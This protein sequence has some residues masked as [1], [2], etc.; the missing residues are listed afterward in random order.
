MPREKH[1]TLLRALGR[2]QRNRHMA[3]AASQR[4]FKELPARLQHH[5]AVHPSARE[6]AP[7]SF[8]AGYK[9]HPRLICTAATMPRSFLVDS[10]I[11]REANDK[12]S[13][14]SSP[15]FP[16][17]V[18][19]PGHHPHGLPGS[20]HS[21]KAGLLCF[22][23]LCM[24]ASQLHP[25]PP[26]LPLL[27]ASFPAFGSQYCH[28]ALSRQHTSS[29]INLGHGA[30]MYQAAYTVPDPRQYHCISIE[31]SNSKLQSSKRMRTAFTSTQL[32]ELEREFTSNMYL[33]RLRRI[34]IATYLNLSEKQVKIWFQ[35]RRVKHKKEGKSGSGGPRTATNG[36][37]CSS[38]ARC[39]EE[40]EEDM[41]VSPS[42]FSE[43]DD[44]DLS[45][46]P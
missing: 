41:P 2:L 34:E 11:L 22:C 12:G 46:S 45:V 14:N 23:P 8:A 39:S 40:E 36:C 17:A 42:S 44:V 18:H 5:F 16:Y 31:N 38:A 7:T 27:K 29:N 6:H 4:L 30:A 33:S 25:S 24:A 1:K 26:A 20:C 19:S 35:N 43:K 9:T 3:E 21:R 13:E 10:L 28:T 32:L 15:L 37:K